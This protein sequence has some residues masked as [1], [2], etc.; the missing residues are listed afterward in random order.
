MSKPQETVSVS[1][2][3]TAQAKFTTVKY[4]AMIRMTAPTGPEAKEKAQPIIQALRKVLDQHAKTAEIDMQRLQTDF[5]VELIEEQN[6]VTGVVHIGYR[7]TYTLGCTG[8]N[9][10]AASK[11]HD[12]LTSIPGVTAQ[13][14]QFCVDK[15]LDLE[16]TAFE[17]GV[18]TA[19]KRFEYQCRALGL[20][21]S[22]YTIGTWSM[23]EDRG[24]RGKVMAAMSAESA[25]GGP[26]E[27]E[28]GKA[29]HTVNVNVTFVRKSR[30]TS[31]KDASAGA[32]VAGART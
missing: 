3:G 12:A 20:N 11:F 25:G 13:S 15:A 8:K 1:A 27:L 18:A 10:A 30:S 26:V 22:N 17:D 2:Q 24:Y 21:P 28:P 9:V 7:A 4:S 16:K 23:H 31:S 19:K 6:H 32:P 14:P 5:P 29:E